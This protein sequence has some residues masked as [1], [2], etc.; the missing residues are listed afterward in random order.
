MRPRM[1]NVEKTC[2]NNDVIPD[3]IFEVKLL[4]DKFDK[5]APQN[6]C[7]TA[8]AA[9]LAIALDILQKNY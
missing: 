1:R 9:Q 5:V 4:L 6:S 2:D 8:A 7:L 3:L